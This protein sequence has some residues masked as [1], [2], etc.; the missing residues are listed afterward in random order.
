MRSEAV[1]H[2]NTLRAIMES[3]QRQISD[4]NFNEQ[5]REKLKDRLRKSW[6]TYCDSQN[7]C[8]VRPNRNGFDQVIVL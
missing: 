4:D 8:I 5:D 1:K 3:Y 2:S 6:H 7:N